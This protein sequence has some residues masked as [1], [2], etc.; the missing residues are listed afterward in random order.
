MIV[1]S[2]SA[3]DLPEEK[4]WK[5]ISDFSLQIYEKISDL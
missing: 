3:K 2:Y 1:R 4:L 5:I